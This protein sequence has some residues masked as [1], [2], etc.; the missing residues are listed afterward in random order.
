MARLR[1]H[2]KLDK[3][4]SGDGSAAFAGDSASTR[5]TTPAEPG[6]TQP[7]T[8][9]SEPA[10]ASPFSAE[11]DP[12]SAGPSAVAVPNA[13]TG[14]GIGTDVASGTVGTDAATGTAVEPAP[15]GAESAAAT[16]PKPLSPAPTPTLAGRVW[17]GLV[18]AA[19]LLVL[20]IIFIAE[21]TKSVSVNFLGA[22]GHI[23]LG[24]ALLIAIVFGIVVTLLVGSA[25]I[26]QL[27]LELRRHRR[28]LNDL[29]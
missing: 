29:S 4:E 12:D 2:L 17:V 22:H 21:N 24:L 11:A 25:R 23:S 3:S 15:A 20:L 18:V 13:A 6:P 28:K 10:D 16:E 9:F 1:S 5:A 14:T 8:A 7:V 26:V 27:S 19:V